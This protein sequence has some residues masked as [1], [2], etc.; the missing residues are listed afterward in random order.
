MTQQQHITKL[1]EEQQ[2]LHH[3]IHNKDKDLLFFRKDNDKLER[4]KTSG[5]KEMQAYQNQIT[6]TQKQNLL[7]IE[8]VKTLRA[9]CDELDQ[10]LARTRNTDKSSIPT[11]PQSAEIGT[12]R[13]ERATAGGDLQT[14]V[15]TEPSSSEKEFLQRMFTQPA[16]V[17]TSPA[18]TNLEANF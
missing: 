4:A 2:Q 15:Q 17:P 8:E 14:R 11:K 18:A 13:K 10:E 3:E 9:R 7:L 16:V 5:A 1:T 6:I 12:V